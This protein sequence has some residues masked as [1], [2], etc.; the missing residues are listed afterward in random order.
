[1]PDGSSIPLQSNESQSISNV[2]PTSLNFPGNSTNLTSSLPNNLTNNLANNS[3]FSSYFNHAP[4]IEPS[5]SSCKVPSLAENIKKKPSQ[6]NK[7]RK[8][9][10]ELPDDVQTTTLKCIRNVLVET[11]ATSHLDQ[12]LDQQLNQ[13]LSEQLDQKTDQ[14]SPGLRPGRPESIHSQSSQCS[15]SSSMFSRCTREPPPNENFSQSNLIVDDAPSDST[16]TS[17]GTTIKSKP[18]RRAKNQPKEDS[19]EKKA[20]SLERNRVSWLRVANLDLS[21]KH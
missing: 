14:H 3:F 13:K 1:M 5:F 10:I 6:P 4:I 2:Q 11:S 12:Q 9:E 17:S 8:S 18:G 20:R 15:T 19:I 21:L 7:R 16:P